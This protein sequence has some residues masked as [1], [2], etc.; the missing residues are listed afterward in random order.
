MDAPR[1]YR[2]PRSTRVVF[3]V[4]VLFWIAGV[5]LGIYLL[6]RGDMH[7]LLAISCI[8]IFGLSLRRTLPE[9]QKVRKFRLILGPDW[10]QYCG[11]GGEMRLSFS[12]IDRFAEF[13]MHTNEGLPGG[14]S[15]VFGDSRTG[16]RIDF[17]T[18][19]I[20]WAAVVE[21]VHSCIPWVVPSARNLAAR[22]MIH[23]T[24]M[25]MW[26]ASMTAPGQDIPEEWHFAK[27]TRWF[28]AW[29][30]YGGVTAVL[31][32]WVFILGK[33]L[34]HLNIPSFAAIVVVVVPFLYVVDRISPRVLQ[35]IRDW[36]VKRHLRRTTSEG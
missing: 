19:V 11:S 27:R 18:Q 31:F 7:P 26:A 24:E 29:I 8:A 25:D 35:A 14:Y 9:W 17:S 33:W 22:R 16:R 15:F 28:D 1:V 4:G 2:F 21:Y 32:P 3:F 5:S 13:P 12:E 34:D 6:L 36:R 20:G 23:H 30:A 10:V